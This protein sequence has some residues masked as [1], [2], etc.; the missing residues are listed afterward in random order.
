MK[1]TVYESDFRQ[2]FLTSDNYKT[3]FSYEG[4][5]I[6]FDYLEQYEQDTGEELDF[7]LVGI[8]CDWYEDTPEGIAEDYGIDLDGVD[9]E[10]IPQAVMDWLCDHTMVAGQTEN[11]SFVY[12]TSF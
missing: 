11:G 2:A 10:D 7:D 8:A 12:C 9:E 6:L 4:L 5:G 1:Q 3:R